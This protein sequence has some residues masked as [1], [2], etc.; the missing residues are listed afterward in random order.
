MGGAKYDYYELQLYAAVG[1]YFQHVLYNPGSGTLTNLSTCLQATTTDPYTVIGVH[2]SLIGGG[3]PST[4][5]VVNSGAAP[6]T[7]PLGIY[8]ARDGSKI[9]SYTT[10][11]IPPGAQVNLSVNTLETAAHVTPSAG[12]YH[13]V[14]KADQP[15]AGFLQHTVTNIKAGAVTDMTTICLM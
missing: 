14:I 3:F 1:G 10:A 5:T 7:V 13:Y 11:T 4:I 9:G 8:D 15:F 6:L 12:E 2:S